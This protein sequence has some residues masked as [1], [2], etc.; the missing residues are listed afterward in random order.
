MSTAIEH[1]SLTR[2]VSRE[3]RDELLRKAF[4]AF[5]RKDEEAGYSY[6]A[7]VPLIPALAEFVLETKGREYCEAHFNLYE[8]NKGTVKK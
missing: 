2:H 8:I 7:Q 1:S 5:D 6:L 3:E 4:E